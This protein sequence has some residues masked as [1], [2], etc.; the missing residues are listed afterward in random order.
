MLMGFTVRIAN[1]NYKTTTIASGQQ[2]NGHKNV[3]RIIM[4]TE[5]NFCMNNKLNR[6]ADGATGW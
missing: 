5:Y 4:W 3:N 2:P 1:A 6:C